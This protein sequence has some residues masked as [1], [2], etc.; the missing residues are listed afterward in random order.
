MPNLFSRFVKGLPCFVFALTIVLS[1]QTLAQETAPKLTAGQWQADVKFL[2][3]ELPKRHRNAFHRMK[4]EEFEAAV[5]TL[6]DR[7]PAINEDEIIVGMMKIVAM[8]KD[9]HTNIIARP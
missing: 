2:G 6:H 5:K 7:V 3:E 1:A 8:I 4:R 9:G